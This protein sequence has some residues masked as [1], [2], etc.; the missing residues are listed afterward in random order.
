MYQAVL[1]HHAESHHYRPGQEDTARRVLSSMGTDDGIY[2]VIRE[3][4]E[5]LAVYQMW[6][7]SALARLA[8]FLRQVA[9]GQTL[10]QSRM[11]ARQAR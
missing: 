6:R 7:V 1:V 8:A 4:Q 9:A 11:K 3:P 10:S 2:T 5:D